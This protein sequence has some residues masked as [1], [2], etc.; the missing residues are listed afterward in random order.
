MGWVGVRVGV[1]GGREHISAAAMT[2]EMG[3]ETLWCYLGEHLVILEG[4]FAVWMGGV[5]LGSDSRRSF[6]Y[7]LGRQR[8][9]AA[10]MTL[11]GG[12]GGGFGWLRFQTS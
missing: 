5:L 10:A 8:I 6:W 7:S 4:V 3:V 11:S 12:G 2:L 1:G 9:S